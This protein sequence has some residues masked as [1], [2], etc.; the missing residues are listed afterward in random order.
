[1]NDIKLQFLE[2]KKNF[3]LVYTFFFCLISF[4]VFLP[5]LLNGK[6]LVFN[7]DGLEQVYIAFV[8]FGNYLRSLFVNLFTNP[9]NFSIPL[10]DNNIG[11]G[12]DIILVLHHNLGSPLNF[13]SIFASPKYAEIVYDF[14]VLAHI[15]LTGISFAFYCFTIKRDAVSTMFGALAYAFC[16]YNLITILIY[17]FLIP[18]IVLPLLF[19]GIERILS[20]EKPHLFIFA[21]FISLFSS[22]YMFYVESLLIFFYLILRLVFFTGEKNFKVLISKAALSL[23][24]IIPFY[25]IGILCSGIISIPYL[26]SVLDLARLDIPHPAPLF[27]DADFYRAAFLSLTVNAVNFISDYWYQLKM[28]YPV[29]FIA[30]LAVI[31]ASKKDSRQLKL[32]FIFLTLCAVFPIA[33]KIFNGF[34][35]VTNRWI[36]AYSFLAAL[37]IVFSV[38]KLIQINK[39]QFNFVCILSAVF[40][41]FFIYLLIDG[42]VV[43]PSILFIVSALF[44]INA[45]VLFYI[46]KKRPQPLLSAGI[47]FLLMCAN[48]IYSG[49]ILY[50]PSQS[51]IR[52]SL[53]YVD[54]GKPFVF[55]N[56]NSQNAVKEIGDKSFNRFEENPFDERVFENGAMISGLQGTSYY[57]SNHNKFI[58][59]FYK[60]IEHYAER[61]F[62][63]TGLDGRV[64][65][66]AILNVKYYIAAQGKE[67]YVP[68]GYK[69]VN[70]YTAYNGVVYNAY[71]NENFLPFGY[72]YKYYIPRSLYNRFSSLQKQQTMSQAIVLDESLPKG[73]NVLANPIFREIP[74]R[75][76]IASGRGVGIE[77]NLSGKG[78]GIYLLNLY[79]N[80]ASLLLKGKTAPESEVYIRFGNF[81]FLS[82]EILNY[83]YVM[84]SDTYKNFPTLTSLSPWTPDKKDYLVNLG[85]AEKEQDTLGIVFSLAGVYSFD[86]IGVFSLPLGADFKRELE[87][88]KEDVLQNVKIEANK[89]SGSIS[90]KENKILFLSLPYSK[91]WRAFVNGKKAKTLRG[92]TMGTAIPLTAGNYEIVLKYRTPGLYLGICSSLLGLILFAGIYCRDRR[93]KKLR[94]GKQSQ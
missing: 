84:T 85:W 17:S 54:S 56:E 27:Y 59:D 2:N 21:V 45:A 89:I 69:K 50:S 47:L 43:A 66:D 34:I 81:K 32:A 30:A 71:Q 8:Y 39:R 60:E 15:Y 11:Y 90:L 44:L 75:Y 67:R 52:Y 3:L 26:L 91:G 79:E 12:S 40:I 41:A 23:A 93:L 77:R 5:F 19:A 87:S 4:F 10:W 88:L 58:F 61:D 49:F 94:S 62:R 63:Y 65:P 86:S 78:D 92:N 83:V 29:L 18:A 55:L 31:F 24:G 20:K 51:G 42:S 36:S 82:K 28:G 16:G 53:W 57:F 14:V 9:F 1:M 37:F 76:E 33:G 13:L 46:Y 22:F 7:F 35:Y 68:N 80:N 70:S 48:I 73:F 74:I 38:P 64:L 72:S 25:L 6:S